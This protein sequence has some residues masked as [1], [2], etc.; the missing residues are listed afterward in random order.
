M[1]I[2][3]FNDTELDMTSD[4]EDENNNGDLD[5][6]WITDIEQH[7]DEYGKFYKDDIFTLKVVFIY[8]NF[9]KDIEHVSSSNIDLETKNI[10]TH[11]ELANIIY[12][13]NKINNTRYRLLRCYLYNIDIDPDDLKQFIQKQQNYE[14][15][16]LETLPFFNK[17]D[18]ARNILINPTISQFHKMNTLYLIMGERE[19][20]NGK[21][22]N[23]ANTNETRTRK[24]KRVRFHPDVKHTR[25]RLYTHI[26]T[27][28]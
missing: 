10:L 24:I 19:P 8:T 21:R 15:T 28:T 27:E 17:V 3:Q 26:N 16:T 23:N 25:R 12:T 2:E 20:T 4:I 11:A 5:M 14:Q 7:N 13:K 1:E 22:H 9:D 18:T 6:N